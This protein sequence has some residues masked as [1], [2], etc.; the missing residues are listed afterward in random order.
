M[1]VAHNVSI[2]DNTTHPIDF[3][4]RKHQIVGQLTGKGFGSYDL[5]PLP[6]VLKEGSWI[7]ANAIILRGVTVEKFEIVSAG[8]VLKRNN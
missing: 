5:R 4:Q 8:C 3:E 6:V 1:I 7:C 2:F